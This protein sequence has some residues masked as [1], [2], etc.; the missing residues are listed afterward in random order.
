MCFS[1]AFAFP[2]GK[3]FFP[4][5]VLSVKTDGWVAGNEYLKSNA[6]FTAGVAMRF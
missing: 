6:S 5:F 2:A 3:H 4:Y 1:G